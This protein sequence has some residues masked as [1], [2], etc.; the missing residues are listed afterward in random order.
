MV[1]LTIPMSVAT[2]LSFASGF[3]FDAVP[4][5]EK[6]MLLPR[7]EKLTVLADP[8]GRRRLDEAA[9]QPSNPLPT[10]TDWSTKLIYDV[11]APE[12]EQYRGRYVGEIAAEEG[13]DPFDTL[14]D[15][16]V[17]DEL[18][19]SFGTP[20]P[21]DTKA[22]WE[23]RLAI[24]RDERSVIGGSDAGAHL[25]L[26]ATFNYATVMLEEAVRHYEVLSLEEAVHLLTD[27]Q[28]QLY[29]I[30]KRGRVT[31][32]WFADLVVFDPTRVG[33]QQVSMR[34]D[35]PGGAGRLYA[36]A[37]G[38]DHV[39]VNGVPVVSNG[40]LTVALNGRLLRSGRDT[41]TALLD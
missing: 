22:D 14:C 15:I 11:V 26:L 39:L 13:R 21:A 23:A 33:S 4:G 8:V 19:T 36:D 7:A 37:N 18:L 41:A 38:I 32:G 29:G 27:V 24:W 31:K 34:F 20:T 12:N 16:V 6:V 10:I 1:G 30:R 25:D 3:V 17:A 5:W 2:R 40:E 28:A 9:R 35:L